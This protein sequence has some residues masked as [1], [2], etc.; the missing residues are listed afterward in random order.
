[1]IPLD[2]GMCPDGLKAC[3]K[4]YLAE[5]GVS[6]LDIAPTVARVMGFA[7][8]AEREGRAIIE[9]QKENERS[10]KGSVCRFFDPITQ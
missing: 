8:D 1:M 9:L 5:Q 3:G 6:L 10:E 7:P 2:G 4:P